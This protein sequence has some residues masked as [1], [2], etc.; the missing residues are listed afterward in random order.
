MRP[1]EADLSLSAAVVSCDVA[2]RS[3]G[4]SSMGTRNFGWPL[5]AVALSAQALSACST[6][7]NPQVGASAPPEP[8]IPAR[9]RP[10]EIASRS[11]Y[12]AC[13]KPE[14]RTGTEAQTSGT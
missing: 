1:V 4:R 13:L 6:T 5:V 14:G 11:G 9:V 8:E 7:P 10:T 2:G 3:K 12:A